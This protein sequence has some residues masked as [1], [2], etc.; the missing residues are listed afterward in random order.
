MP[1]TYLRQSNKIKRGAAGGARGRSLSERAYG[2]ID[3]GSNSLNILGQRGDHYGI[4]R[5]SKKMYAPRSGIL[6]FS[7]HL[8]TALKVIE[9]S[10]RPPR[11]PAAL[12]NRRPPMRSY[13]LLAELGPHPRPD[14]VCLWG[15]TLHRMLAELRRLFIWISHSEERANQRLLGQLLENKS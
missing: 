5:S 6:Q 8:L 7:P 14:V 12:I 1:S 11:G 10:A 13:C 4:I 15:F 3:N 2:I 9:R